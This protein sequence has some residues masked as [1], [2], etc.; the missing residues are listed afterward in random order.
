MAGAADT[1]AEAVMAAMITL[2]VA[3]MTVTVVAAATTEVP[4]LQIIA[5]AHRLQP[6][7]AGRD[8]AVVTDVA[9]VAEAVV[10]TGSPITMQGQMPL[11]W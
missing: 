9:K 5:M 6:V 11:R 4:L 10:A 8:E 7:A 1:M 3:M 2:D